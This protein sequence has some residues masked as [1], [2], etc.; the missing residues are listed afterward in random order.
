MVSLSDIFKNVKYGT[1]SRQLRNEDK[2]ADAFAQQELNAPADSISV[3][4]RVLNALLG[5]KANSND[6]IGTPKSDNKGNVTIDS[7][8]SQTP[9]VGGVLNDF[10]KG[11]KDNRFNPINMYQWGEKKR[12]A[13]RLGEGLGSLVRFGES[14][15]GRSLIVGGLVG[16]T[17]GNPLQSLTYGTY[18]GMLNQ[19]NRNADRIYRDDLI[20]SQQTA[21]R[22]SPEYATMTPEEQQTQ[23]QNISDNINAQR[24]Y[25][26]KDIY[27][28]LINTQQMRDNADWRKFYF[29][30]QQ[31]NNQ[32]NREFQQ[33]Q[34]D[35]S[36]AQANANRALQWAELNERKRQNDIS[37]DIAMAKL[38]KEGEF[39][40]FSEIEQQLNNFQN[41]FGKV[42]NP[43]RYRIAGG[44]SEALNMLT[45]EES[46]FNSQ[47]TLLFNQ[48]ARKLGGEKG[49]LSDQDIK[50]IDAA[51]PKLSDT[52]QQK[53]AK[54][55][56]VYDLLDIKKGATTQSDPLGI[57]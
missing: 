55:Q 57:L 48:I 37:N 34:L 27:S 33:R 40:E 8:I 14:P 22:N 36:T 11:Y 44:T 20:T 18:T 51:L 43:Y 42:N 21:F 31:E 25:F 30:T 16:A 19:A 1:L 23:L 17:G 6:T 2:Q 39:N 28:N 7:S 46:N 54:M 10:I 32:I 52:L 29:D 9:R 50:R 56:A 26:N 47:R 4:D 38:L 15:L 41:S 49:V 53:Q 5:K 24:G 3:G 12:T 13:E 45:P 35:N